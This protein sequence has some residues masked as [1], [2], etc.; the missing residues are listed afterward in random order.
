MKSAGFI[1]ERSASKNGLGLLEFESEL[2]KVCSKTRREE[3][4]VRM[5][6]LASFRESYDFLEAIEGWCAPINR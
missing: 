6:S 1:A 3:A 2:L 5:A 4:M